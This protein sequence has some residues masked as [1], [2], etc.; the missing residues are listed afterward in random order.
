[1]ADA[2]VAA[3]LKV[4]VGEDIHR[5]RVSSPE[6]SAIQAAVSEFAA[7]GSVYLDSAG[8]GD[9]LQPLTEASWEMA[10]DAALDAGATCPPLVRLR[11]KPLTQLA[12]FVGDSTSAGEPQRQESEIQPAAEQPQV[13]ACPGEAAATSSAEAA[14]PGAPVLLRGASAQETAPTEDHA[15]AHAEAHAQAQAQHAEAHARAQEQTHPHPLE[16][17]GRAEATPRHH[18]E[19]PHP[20]AQFA[21][22]GIQTGLQ[23]AARGLQ[24]AQQWAATPRAGG[25]GWPGQSAYGNQWQQGLGGQ[26]QAQ[27][28]QNGYGQWQAQSRR[29]PQWQQW[30]GTVPARGQTAANGALP[31]T[32]TE[33]FLWTGPT[34]LR[35]ERRRLS[36]GMITGNIR[37]V[38]CEVELVDT[39]VTGTV[40]LA[41]SSRLVLVRGMITGSVVHDATSSFENHG[42]M[43]TGAVRQSG[44]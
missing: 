17:E 37:F 28:A 18:E 23:G 38:D 24:A 20:G 2:P 4:K 11:V 40:M 19:Q 22:W 1:M 33:R 3:V 13:P 14:V 44:Q 29:G 9:E 41:G 16:R 8:A 7:S 31:V 21:M 36:H 10:Y 42:G 26:W 34:E 32:E 35:N 30:Q 5:L 12:A 43:M 15:R 25:T 39:M 6:F 27:S